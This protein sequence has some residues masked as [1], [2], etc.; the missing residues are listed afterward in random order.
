[1]EVLFPSSGVQTELWLP[2][3][4]TLVISFCTSMAGASAA[5]LLAL[6]PMSV[7]GHHAG[8]R[9]WLRRA[10]HTVCRNVQIAWLANGCGQSCPPGCEHQ[11]KLDPSLQSV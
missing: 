7:S 6:D 3:L 2:P 10:H 5:F 1:M 9:V 4:V 8:N 11:R